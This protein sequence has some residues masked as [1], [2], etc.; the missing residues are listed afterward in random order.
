MTMEENKL[1]TLNSEN[2]LTETT[3][4]DV[5]DAWREIGTVVGSAGT[6][7][8]TFVLKSFKA[9]I[10]DIVAVV[11]EVPEHGKQD[12]REICVWARVIDISRSNP[13]FPNEAAQALADEGLSLLDTVLSDARDQ[14]EARALVLGSTQVDEFSRLSPLTYPIKPASTVLVPPAE[15][16]RHLLIG[17][18]TGDVRLQVGTLIARRDVEAS[19]SARRLVSRHMAILAMT[20]GGKTVAARRMIRELSAHGYPLVILDPHGD[21]IGLW[22]VREK[23]EGT[24][25]RLFF[26]ELTI[27]KDGEAIIEKLIGQM[28]EA[29]SE[30][31]ADALS[32]V[33]ADNAAKPGQPASEYIK[34]LITAVHSDAQ[35]TTNRNQAR[36]LYAVLRKLR[37]V[38]GRLERM[39]SS[40]AALRKRLA[41]FE[42][43]PLPDPFG[44]PELI[45]RPN[46]ISIVY[47]GGYD[48]VT[49]CSIAAI[50][51]ETLFEHRSNLSNR[52]APFATVIEEA[53][54]FIPSARE[55][56]TDAVTLPVVR[57]IITEGRKFGTGLILISQRPSRL[58]ET[59][60]SQCNSFLILRLVNPRDQQFVRTV[61]E[62]LTESDARMI[63]G[64]G[65]GQGIV[66]GQVVRFPLPVMIR[67]DADLQ[68][69]DLADEDFIRAASQWKSVIPEKVIAQAPAR[70]Q[71]QTAL[72]AK[73]A[74]RTA[75]PAKKPATGRTRRAG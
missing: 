67:M 12:N 54:T 59:I 34:V 43:E 16:V 28:A 57:R 42:F 30:P 7:D 66:S 19:I 74:K 25:V 35:A 47:L 75:R 63:P 62:N 69:S 13:F 15:A 38:Q 20:G 53:H 58:D 4:P 52:I 29:M 45:V 55:G 27:A 65:P 24:N 31:Q 1:G 21:Y 51:L 6:T 2:V 36:T 71:K 68:A 18:T 9:T 39:K 14:L 17:D 73:A 40:N 5:G 64:F 32:G 8:F 11:M 22:S 72:A 37:I 10:G 61:M 46:Q 33:I 56:T 50:L 48:H 70:R 41:S 26:P 49:Q 44:S 23:F 3:E 60:I